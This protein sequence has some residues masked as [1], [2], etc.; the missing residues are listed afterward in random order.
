MAVEQDLKGI[1]RK[2]FEGTK[3]YQNTKKCR[4]ENQN[5]RKSDPFQETSRKFKKPEIQKS[6]K[7]EIQKIRNAE[8]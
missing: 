1:S 5:S 7:P 8:N 6:R 4:K 3:T 2:V